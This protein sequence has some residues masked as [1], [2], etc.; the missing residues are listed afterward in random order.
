MLFRVGRLGD[1]PGFLE[2]FDVEESQSRQSLRNRARQQL[3]LLDQLGLIFT[4]VLR[5]RIIWRALESS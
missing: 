2:S 1:P 4:N 3:A 5:T